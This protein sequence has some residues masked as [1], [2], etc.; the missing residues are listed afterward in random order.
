MAGKRR[1]AR[2]GRIQAEYSNRQLE[3]IAREVA[4][5]ANPEDPLRASPAAYDQALAKSEWSD[6]PSARGTRRRFGLAWYEFLALIFSA[7]RDVH[8]TARARRRRKAQPLPTLAEIRYALRL[9]AERLGA[10]TLTPDQ[11]NA[12]RQVLIASD[13][14]AW[15]HGGNIELTLPHSSTIE[16]TLDPHK[17]SGWDEA[18]AVAG[19]EPRPVTS[20]G[21]A[22]TPTITMIGFFF[23]EMGCLPWSQDVLRSFAHLGNQSVRDSRRFAD[24]VEF[25][26]EERRSQGMWAPSGPPAARRRPPL[27]RYVPP[28]G[29]NG[30]V[31]AGPRKRR[32]HWTRAA[33][34]EGLCEAYLALGPGK[35]LDQVTHRELARNSDGLIPWPGQVS[36]YAKAN[37]T[38]P[39]ALRL[40]AQRMAARRRAGEKPTPVPPTLRELAA[41]IG[42]STGSLRDWLGARYPRPEAAKGSNWELTWEMVEAARAWWSRPDEE[43]QQDRGR[44]R[45]QPGD[46]LPTFAAELGISLN[47]LRE[48]LRRNYEKPGPKNAVWVLTDEMKEAARAWRANPPKPGERRRADADRGAQQ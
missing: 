4:A 31:S 41:E 13:Q 45:R 24:L 20:G 7:E 26:A 15:R 44:G 25:F 3:Q 14:R 43:R 38:T 11:Y 2:S 36:S 33:I 10:R 17:H 34:L 5:K 6:A 23:E 9:L 40:E 35:D 27:Q 29:G 32:G 12:E 46:P 8:A 47:H 39:E 30:N 48:W 21:V 37:R 28:E 42:A 18:L 1:D 22:G 19:L 16:Q